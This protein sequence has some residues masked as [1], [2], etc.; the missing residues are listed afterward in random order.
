M[1]GLRW[2][3]LLVLADGA[4]LPGAI[5]AEITSNS[6]FAA[7]RFEITLA[8]GAD[9][10]TLL[11]LVDRT[12]VTLDI[13]LSLDDG[14]GFTSLVTGDVD[15]I[16]YDPLHGT[17]TL[18]GRD[19]SA[20]LMEARRGES[21]V[22][23]TAAEIAT[24]LA[25]RHGLAAD[26]QPTGLPAGRLWEGS[27][28][29]TQLDQ[30]SRATTEW[31]LLCALADIEGF[32]LWVSGATL[33][34]RPPAP[35]APQPLAI[36]QATGVR[37]ERALTLAGGIEVVVRSWS[38]ERQAGCE[39]R[40][41][42]GGGRQYVYVVPNLTQAEA[43][44]LATQRLAAIGRHERAIDIDMPGE[45]DIAPRGQILLTGSG[46]GFDQPYWVDRVTRHIGPH[47]FR[48]TVLARNSNEG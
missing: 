19:F 10:V 1:S 42:Q 3:R 31:D 45:L 32:D 18:D 44:S 9:P 38:A 47:G 43:A 4:P 22:N 36:G 37:L 8:A 33:H 2:P 48:Q 41:G 29:R 20:R 24:T 27:R 11:D 40:A 12:D 39:E 23:L 6:H 7:D 26:V 30:F 5:H 21:F 13:Q 46:T 25:G 35:A 15:R 17:I 14:A 28:Q 16:A 34:F